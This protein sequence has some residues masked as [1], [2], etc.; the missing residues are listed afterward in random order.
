M[1]ILPDHA[2][3]DFFIF[4]LRVC[5]RGEVD[6]PPLLSSPQNNSETIINEHDNEIPKERYISPKEI[7]KIIDDRRLI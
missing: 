3:T 4:D 2:L 5:V 1:V 6:E 7:Y